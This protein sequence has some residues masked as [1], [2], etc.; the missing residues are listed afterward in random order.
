MGG[1]QSE[2]QRPPMSRVFA[3]DINV[4]PGCGSKLRPE[5]CE[6]ACDPVLVARILLALGLYG[7]A[8]AR[9]PPRTGRSLFDN[10]DECYDADD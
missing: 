8:P 2:D 1:R 9:A 6:L 10:I 4:C 7:R 3:V 5:S